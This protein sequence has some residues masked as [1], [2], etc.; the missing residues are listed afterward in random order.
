MVLA[1]G[2]CAA[3]AFANTVYFADFGDIKYDT[4]YSF[5]NGAGYFHTLGAKGI[6]SDEGV[7]FTLTPSGGTLWLY[8]ET[9]SEQS[10]IPG[11]S[12]ITY[13][14]SNKYYTPDLYS[15]D[16]NDVFYGIPYASSK[17]AD[18]SRTIDSTVAESLD[19]L[20]F[21]NLLDIPMEITLISL[22][23]A[24]PAATPVPAAVWLLGTGVAGV[25]ALR[26]KMK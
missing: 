2:L 7:T 8:F 18:G 21:T 13:K 6:K 23:F 12:S 19:H 4:N 15:N 5:S 11:I 26:R 22:T 1:L 16:G 24:E 3:P 25:A 14:S 20:I 10:G 9:S 17:N